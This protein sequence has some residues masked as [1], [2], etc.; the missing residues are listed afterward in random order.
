MKTETDLHHHLT[1]AALSCLEE[2]FLLCIPNP[3]DSKQVVGISQQM[4]LRKALGNHD[5]LELGHIIAR[6]LRETGRIK[7]EPDVSNRARYSRVPNE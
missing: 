7:A 3:G 4:G 6:R 1:E 2:S 5:G